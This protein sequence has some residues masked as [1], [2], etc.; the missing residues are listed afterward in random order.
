[1]LPNEDDEKEQRERQYL[2][3]PPRHVV[4]V[5]PLVRAVPAPV[6][7][8]APTAVSLRVHSVCSPPGGGR[9][10][11]LRA[12]CRLDR[13]LG[14]GSRGRPARG[15]RV[16]RTALDPDRDLSVHGG[17]G[18]E[19]TV[20]FGRRR[21]RRGRRG[22]VVRRLRGGAG[23]DD[24]G[25]LEER[26]EGGLEEA[27]R[28]EVEAV[29]AKPGGCGASARS[30]A[31]AIGGGPRRWVHRRR[32]RRRRN[33]ICRRRTRRRARRGH[34]WNGRFLGDPLRLCLGWSALSF[35]FWFRVCLFTIAVTTV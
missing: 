5:V 13:V 9:L 19:E 21:R 11:N 7:R 32:D 26:R 31:P 4:H 14:R 35:R 12:G 1:M 6:P 24:A 27:G 8:C 30:V 25:V 2:L 18:G 22:R 16:A 29:A 28:R 3:D 33:P 34:L 20:D 10:V 15:L 17:R 23:G